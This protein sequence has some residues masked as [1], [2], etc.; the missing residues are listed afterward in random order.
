MSNVKDHT[1][2]VN[3]HLSYADR[4]E[5]VIGVQSVKYKGRLLRHFEEV[6][7]DFVLRV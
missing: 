1:F 7:L 2:Q 5:E 4:C 6:G 3:G